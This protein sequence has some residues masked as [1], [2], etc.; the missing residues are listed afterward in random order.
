M[1]YAPALGLSTRD[2]PCPYRVCS[3]ACALADAKPA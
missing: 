1:G 2:L 3:A